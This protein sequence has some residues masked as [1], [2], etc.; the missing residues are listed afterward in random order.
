MAELYESWIGASEIWEKTTVFLNITS[1]SGS[2]SRGSRKWMTRTEMVAKLGAEATDAIINNKEND[3]ALK[4]QIRDHPDC[5]G[6]K[7]RC[8]P[9]HS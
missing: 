4:S 2:V 6:V 8:G 1:K 3:P 7:A 9:V 5:P